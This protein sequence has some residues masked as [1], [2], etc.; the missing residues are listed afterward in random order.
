MRVAVYTAIFGNIDRLWSVYPLA[1]GKADWVCFTDQNL[2]EVGL[3]T[4]DN[5]PSLRKNTREMGVPP[6]WQVREAKATYGDRR[7][8]R[9]YKALPHYYLP[10]YDFWIWVDGNVRPLLPPERLVERY[11]G[12]SDLAIFKHP[13][14][15]C[16][17]TEADFCAQRGKDRPKTLSRQTERYRA[18]GMPPGWGLPETRC[19]IRRNCRSIVDLN[20]CWWQQMERYS[21]RDQV[22]LPYCC[23]KAGFKWREIPGRCWE[24][25]TH[26]HFYFVKHHT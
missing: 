6:V 13:D 4:D 25:N 19:V 20:V 9:H 14:R 22:S 8:A 1:A 12:H 23:W 10:D 11:L 3:W 2:R 5:P 15:N 17:Y 7:T 21:Y 18:E 16:L 24:R 26:E